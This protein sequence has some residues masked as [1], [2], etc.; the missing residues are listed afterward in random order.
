MEQSGRLRPIRYRAGGNSYLR[1][2]RISEHSATAEDIQHECKA[3]QRIESMSATAETRQVSTD[4][5][6]I[7]ADSHEIRNRLSLK[8]RALRQNLLALEGVYFLMVG[9]GVMVELG[10]PDS[11]LTYILIHWAFM[12]FFGALTL[13]GLPIM[14]GAFR[15]RSWSRR[16]LIL[17]CI[18]GLVLFPLGSAFAIGIL[19][20]LFSG[21]SPRLLTV[22]HERAARDTPELSPRTSFLSWVGLVLIII[23]IG[24]MI[25]I[26][27]LPPE[28]RRPVHT[29]FDHPESEFLAPYRNGIG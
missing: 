4:D 3:N 8:E 15:Q 10:R 14:F 16:P 27:N 25:L 11:E 22:G 24:S 20:D 21:R 1:M 18:P 28:Y 7:A 19:A 29:G 12:G 13:A 9:V 2:T 26:S 6:E 23:L 5:N 17:L